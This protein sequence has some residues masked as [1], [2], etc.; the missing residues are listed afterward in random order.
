MSV[1]GGWR[2]GA[3]HVL[4]ALGRAR[5]LLRGVPDIK[6]SVSPGKR[7]SFQ[8]MPPCAGSYLHLP[9]AADT[10][11]FAVFAGSGILM[12]TFVAKSL[13]VNIAFT[14]TLTSR[15]VRPSSLTTG[16]TRNGKLT[17]SVMRYDISW[18]SPSGGTNEMVRSMSN[19]PNLTHWWNDTSSI[20]MPLPGRRAFAACQERS[21]N[22]TAKGCQCWARELTRA[23]G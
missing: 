12:T 16:N 3:W 22:A 1:Y 13:K 17:F 10:F 11:A 5:V 21:A 2:G 15:R 18:N 7:R 4:A 6:Y 23:W 8:M 19:F 14:L 20:S 9:E